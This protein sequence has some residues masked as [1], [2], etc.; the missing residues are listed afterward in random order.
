[1]LSKNISAGFLV[2]LVIRLVPSVFADGLG[3][4]FG[5][6]NDDDVKLFS[7]EGSEQI[8]VSS[9][10]GTLGDFEN[11]RVVVIQS[12]PSF[13][14][15][16][17]GKGSGFDGSLNVI[18]PA[19][20]GGFYFGGDFKTYS[21]TPGTSFMIKV[22]ADGSVDPSFS[23]AGALDGGVYWIVPADD[24]TGDFWIAGNFKKWGGNTVQPLIRISS[25]G[26]L[27]AQI[28]PAAQLESAQ[29]LPISAGD[30]KGG[31][32]AAFGSQIFR[33]DAKG[34]Q[35]ASFVS[36]SR[37]GDIS[38]LKRVSD[39]IL[40]G[41]MNYRNGSVPQQFVN[42]DK[43]GND[44][45]RDHDFQTEFDGRIFDIAPTNDGTDDFY[46]VGEF[47][48]YNGF[49]VS[50]IV[51]LNPH[52][53]LD[54][55]FNPEPKFLPTGV[56]VLSNGN[57]L[58]TGISSVDDSKRYFAGITA[59]DSQGKTVQGFEQN[60]IV[61]LQY[62]YTAQELPNGEILVGGDFPYFGG[63]SDSFDFRL[64]ADGARDIGFSYKSRI[65]QMERAPRDPNS[66]L[67][68]DDQYVFN[69][70][71]RD[72]TLVPHSQVDRVSDFSVSASGKVFFARGREE[73][74]RSAPTDGSVSDFSALE[75]YNCEG[76]KGDRCNW[77]SIG[78]NS[79]M[80][81]P[82]DSVWV[83]GWFNRYG[84]DNVNGVAHLGPDGKLLGTVDGLD[85]RHE[86][87]LYPTPDHTS[88]F[89]SYQSGDYD[90]MLT[91]VDAATGS[92]RSTIDLKRNTDSSKIYDHFAFYNDGSVLAVDRTN[93]LVSLI[94]RMKSDGSIDPDFKSPVLDGQ[95]SDVAVVK[96][97][98]G[99]FLIAGSFTSYNQ[100][101]RFGLARVHS[102]GSL[103]P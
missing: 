81:M 15:R 89:L 11:S 75:F 4:Q 76:D 18:V 77:G 57:I 98:S 1:V 9:K 83:A 90:L 87:S 30:G 91:W 32:I 27:V 42:F 52:G 86:Y 47:S 8:Y 101:K 45:K 22:L 36:E 63:Y 25:K 93:Y 23:I 24:K 59:F 53:L 96:D 97:G 84:T 95:I 29:A 38:A 82:D 94:V 7:L 78:G 39:G 5:V 88:F 73:I 44:G 26:V 33:F 55:S 69:Q 48:H 16:K 79:L 3:S 54:R 68:L 103:V 51:R 21:A 46:V 35:D 19:E 49:Y 80:A 71:A 14:P 62:V 2:L 92:V 102:D 17:F 70:V 6:P 65:V 58:V 43:I 13:Q 20:N 50:D 12:A 100:V 61:S 28:Q 64:N 37:V 99:D 85:P 41:G 31:V 34:L 60:R 72:G 67:V 40:V 66:M 10:T 56:Q 74:T